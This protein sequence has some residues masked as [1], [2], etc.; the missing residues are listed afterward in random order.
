MNDQ[1]ILE[2]HEE[3]LSRQTIICAYVAFRHSELKD[4]IKLLKEQIKERKA[5]ILKVVKTGD[6]E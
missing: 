3:D 2:K 4:N 1:D 5:K 6:K